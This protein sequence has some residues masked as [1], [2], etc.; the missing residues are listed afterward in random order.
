[1]SLLP[2]YV[3]DH[4]EADEHGQREGEANGDRIGVEAEAMLGGKFG[5]VDTRGHWNSCRC[6]SDVGNVSS[7]SRKPT[8]RFESRCVG[9]LEPEAKF[10][11]F[12]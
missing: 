9:A 1:M 8:L 4:V 12:V 2:A 11:A 3:M 5:Y 7:E 6:G 10:G